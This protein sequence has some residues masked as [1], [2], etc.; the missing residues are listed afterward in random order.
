MEIFRRKSQETSLVILLGDYQVKVIGGF[1]CGDFQ[2]RV[3]KDFTCDTHR[4]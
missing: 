4:P 1:T 3:A 2:V